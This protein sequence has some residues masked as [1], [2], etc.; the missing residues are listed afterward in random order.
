MT[1]ET[2]KLVV[3]PQV[4]DIVTINGRTPCYRVELGPTYEN[5]YRCV[6]LPN[7]SQEVVVHLD[8]L[9]LVTEVPWFPISYA[10]K[11]QWVEVHTKASTETFLDKNPDPCVWDEWRPVK[12]K[13]KFQV[14]DVVRGLWPG[15]LDWRITKV[16]DDGRYEVSSLPRGLTDVV[17]QEDYLALVTD[18]EWHPISTAPKDQWVEVHNGTISAFRI[19]PDPELWDKWRPI[20]TP[21]PLLKGTTLNVTAKSVTYHPWHDI[22][23]VPPP[24]DERVLVYNQRTGSLTTWT[25]PYPDF[26]THWSK[27]PTLPR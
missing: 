5:K 22:S 6:S 25:N 4:G 19:N 27:I 10:P 20:V 7:G 23:K 8:D 16:R 11:D 2:M 26:H 17:V 1:E 13:P 3:K 12:H 24:K 15:C 14:G 21:E 18:P 9:T